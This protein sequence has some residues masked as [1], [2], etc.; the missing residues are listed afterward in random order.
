MYIDRKGWLANPASKDGQANVWVT[1][2]ALVMHEQRSS[3]G[4]WKASGSIQVA[5]AQPLLKK[6]EIVLFADVTSADQK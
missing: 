3:T 5:P 1:N 6:D 2:A 4:V